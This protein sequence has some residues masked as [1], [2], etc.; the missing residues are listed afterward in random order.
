MDPDSPDLRVG[1][2]DRAQVAD[3]PLGVI[4]LAV[5]F[6]SALIRGHQDDFWPVWVIGPWGA[7]IA[8]RAAH[9]RID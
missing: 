6:A 1:D 8:A 3:E 5:W 7:V 2:L 9:R 4:C